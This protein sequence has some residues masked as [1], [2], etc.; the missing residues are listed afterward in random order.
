MDLGPSR[1]RRLARARQLGPS[2]APRLARALM[3]ALAQKFHV[4]LEQLDFA[5]SL[6]VAAQSDRLARRQL[7]WIRW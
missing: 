6:L 3:L 7:A 5:E 4:F 2:R 1:A